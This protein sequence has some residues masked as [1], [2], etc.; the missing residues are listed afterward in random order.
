MGDYPSNGMRAGMFKTRRR[1]REFEEKST[2][3]VQGF[4]PTERK[5]FLILKEIFCTSAQ[6]RPLDNKRVSQQCL[7]RLTECREQPHFNEINQDMTS[8]QPVVIFFNTETNFRPQNQSPNGKRL[9][10]LR[11]KRNR[12]AF[13]FW[14]VRLT[15]VLEDRVGFARLAVTTFSNSAQFGL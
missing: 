7:T 12:H 10:P 15:L 14:S 8:T 6:S 1:S 3:R 11:M 4:P 13:S 5:R 9:L 2:G